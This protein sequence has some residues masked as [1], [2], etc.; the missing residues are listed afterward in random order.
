M[1]VFAGTMCRLAAIGW[2]I[3]RRASAFITCQILMF[4]DVLQTVFHLNAIQN[5]ILIFTIAYH[6]IHADDV[7]FVGIFRIAHN[8]CACL[9]PCVATVFVH[10]TVVVCQH[11]T[12]VYNCR[13]KESEA[14]S[15]LNTQK[16]ARIY[17]RSK[18][19][20]LS[21]SASSAWH[22]L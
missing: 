21:L 10:K 9:Q 15:V 11:L 17:S 1:C 20:F 3:P 19:F 7:L 14:I 6:I 2:V 8:R 5:Q 22:K 12:L 4:D 16:L 13:S 18:W